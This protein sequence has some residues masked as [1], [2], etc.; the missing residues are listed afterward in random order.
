MHWWAEARALA[1]LARAATRLGDAAEAAGSLA[2]ALRITESNNEMDLAMAVLLGAAEYALTFGRP[3]IA[4][5]LA[6]ALAASRLTWNE[7]RA[8]A[9]AVAG[10]ARAALDHG[11]A[12][13]AEADGRTMDLGVLMTGLAPVPAET[14]E[15]WFTAV[16]RVIRFLS[17]PDALDAVLG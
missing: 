3:D 14:P 4:L 2:R 11:A 16:T 7:T 17:D 15:A 8:Q 12:S 1:G 10:Q 6:E 13:R 5:T 9:A